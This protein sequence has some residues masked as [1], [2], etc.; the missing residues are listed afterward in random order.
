MVKDEEHFNQNEPFEAKLAL[1]V[2]NVTDNALLN[3]KE[4]VD[5]LK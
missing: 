3:F 4:S 5:M 1:F 2:P